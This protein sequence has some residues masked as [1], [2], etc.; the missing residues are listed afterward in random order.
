VVSGEDL[1]ADFEILVEE[2]IKDREFKAEEKKKLKEEVAIA[3]IKFTVLRQAN[4]G[5]V[6]YDPT[7]AV[8]FE[9]DSGPYLQYATVR[10]QAVLAKAKKEKAKD[11][12][13]KVDLLEKLLIRFPE[14]IERARVEYAPHYIVTYLV[15]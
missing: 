5:D 12:P 15:E 7:K 8:S 2:K 13:E 6:I 1:I 9:G 4:G 10:A 11:L 3:A 14:V